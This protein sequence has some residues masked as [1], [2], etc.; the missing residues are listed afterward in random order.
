MIVLSRKHFYYKGFGYMYAVTKTDEDEI[1]KGFNFI[2]FGKKFGSFL[3]AGG[4]WTDE[5]KK[6]YR[7][8]IDWEGKRIFIRKL[9]VGL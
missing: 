4:D 3:Y 9:A 1:I 7:F 5:N 8:H 2:V 6:P